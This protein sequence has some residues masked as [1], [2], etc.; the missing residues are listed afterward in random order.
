M[1]FLKARCHRTFRGLLAFYL[2]YLG[3]LSIG[4]N[5]KPLQVNSEKPVTD[6]ILPTLGVRREPNRRLGT[7]IRL[8]RHFGN[9][10]DKRSSEAIPVVETAV[11]DLSFGSEIKNPIGLIYDPLGLQAD[12]LNK[13]TPSSPAISSEQPLRTGRGGDSYSYSSLESPILSHNSQ[14]HEAHR[15]PSSALSQ[16]RTSHAA[17]VTATKVALFQPQEVGFRLTEYLP[18]PDWEALGRRFEDITERWHTLN[19]EIEEDRRALGFIHDDPFA[20]EVHELA[21]RS[22]EER[23]EEVER[24]AQARRSARAR[25]LATRYK[26][27]QDKLTKALSRT[28]SLWTRLKAS[29][30]LHSHSTMFLTAPKNPAVGLVNPTL[31]MSVWLFVFDDAMHK[32]RRNLPSLKSAH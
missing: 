27:V 24:I 32:L 13:K 1:T 23:K 15:N 25:V 19:V 8:A 28:R 30:Q 26:T 4:R 7:S 14:W 6:S 11:E 2:I 17:E 5:L 12:L 31:K 20:P 21:L 16:P 22:A 29:W 3:G 9:R 10:L 18:V